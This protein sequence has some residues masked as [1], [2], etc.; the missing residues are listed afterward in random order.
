MFFVE[1]NM[2]YGYGGNKKKGGGCF[3]A[4]FWIVSICFGGILVP[5]VLEPMVAYSMFLPFRGLD[6]FGTFVCNNFAECNDEGIDERRRNSVRIFVEQSIRTDLPHLYTITKRAYPNHMPSEEVIR[7]IKRE[8]RRS[9]E[10][11]NKNLQR[12]PVNVNTNQNGFVDL[13]NMLRDKNNIKF[14]SYGVR[15]DIH[16]DVVR[17]SRFNQAMNEINT[18]FRNIVITATTQGDHAPGKYSHENG[19]KIDIRTKDRS[20]GDIIILMG[21]FRKNNI[22]PVFEYETTKES[23]EVATMVQK[24]GFPIRKAVRSEHLDINLFRNKNG[25]P[26]R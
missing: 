23:R 19:Y 7:E 11:Q 6:L 4:I 12:I 5:H 14:K 9:K 8:A 24:H 2:S 10:D 17:Y 22:Y 26:I 13:R 18:N 25:N 3:M 21:I 15:Y 1:E 20:T 16:P